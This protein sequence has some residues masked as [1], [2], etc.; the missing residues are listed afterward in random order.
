MPLVSAYFVIQAFIR[1]PFPLA[2]S[3]ILVYSVLMEDV[4]TKITEMPKKV[5]RPP[6]RSKDR[7]LNMRVDDEWVAS[8]DEW[9]KRQPGEMLTRTAAIRR[10]VE[11]ALSASAGKGKR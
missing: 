7:P 10:L 11:Q 9:R 3:I 4:N 8:I 2:L 6:G 5:G 1:F